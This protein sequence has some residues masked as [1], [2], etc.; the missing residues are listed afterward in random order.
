MNDSPAQSQTPNRRWLWW[1][2]L[3]LGLL[4]VLAL[5]GMANYFSH[6]HNHRA[7][8]SKRLNNE[9]SPLTL[10]VLQSVENSVRVVVF[11]DR[12]ES[13][14]RPIVELLRQYE[15]R[16]PLLEVE[17]I[18]YELEPAKASRIQSEM[19][20]PGNARNLVIF[21]A[22]KK[23]EVVPH[24][25][26][27]GLSPA[28][29]DEDGRAVFKR[30][31]FNGEQM[32]TS[33]L[34][35]VSNPAKPTV[36]YLSE[37]GTHSFT[38]TATLDGY[39]R[40]SQSLAR[41]NIDLRPLSLSEKAV[42]ADCRL[43]IVPG[44]HNQLDALS[45]SRLRDH[46][47]DGGRQL[48]LFRPH[49]RAGLE[50]LLADWGV[51]VGNDEVNDPGNSYGDGSVKFSKYDWDKERGLHPVMRGLALR[52]MSIRMGAPCSVT[53]LKSSPV[54]GENVQR[55][56]LASTGAQGLTYL[57][58]APGASFPPRR[59][60]LRGYI[61]VAMAVERDPPPGIENAETVRLVVMGDSAWLNNAL[62]DREANAE[63]AWHL[64]NWM[65]DRSQLL[66]IGPRQITDY[67]FSLTEG[68][69]RDLMGWLLGVVP[70][71]ILG[72]GV[73]IWLRRRH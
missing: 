67:Q 47:A 57:R 7:H 25:V 4:A 6:R 50:P 28:Q 45:L 69:H 39:G 2:N 19:R 48:I 70:G 60:G 63:L 30:T 42:P 36:Y 1:V 61:P 22:N 62:Y 73:L 44:P 31:R 58:P 66:A 64:I 15:E 21:H 54:G 3:V 24:G 55:T 14:Y 35:A 29:H 33:A 26:L 41:M 71:S 37:H 51:L 46:L 56:V 5:A 59:V 17:S 27:S 11:Y 32:F 12:R 52:Q 13:L 49:T 9:L 34:V 23:T 10:Q 68:N 65:L 18:D 43:L 16:N 53:D 8:W 38:N 72:L 40:F 20:L